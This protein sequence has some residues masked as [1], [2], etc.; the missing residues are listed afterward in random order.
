MVGGLELK[1][2]GQVNSSSGELLI[3]DPCYLD[4]FNLDS[5]ERLRTESHKKIIKL[6][7]TELERIRKDESEEIENTFIQN[8]MKLQNDLTPPYI[9]QEENY[10]LFRNP[11]GDGGYPVVKT[12]KRFYVMFDYPI[13]NV[14]KGGFMLDENR[15]I[16]G[17][18]L[19]GISGVDSGIQIL[20]DPSHVVIPEHALPENYCRFNV[21]KGI[22]TCKFIESGY[23]LSIKRTKVIR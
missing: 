11:I 10:V 4:D 1:L 21:P 8:I 16:N 6:I 23:T 14:G 7:E 22:Y 13:K 19:I 12:Q 15:L 18:R 20:I 9:G 5:L 2:E 17:G 3:I